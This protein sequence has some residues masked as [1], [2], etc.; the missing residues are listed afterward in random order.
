MSADRT[1]IAC[2][3]SKTLRLRVGHHSFEWSFLLAAVAFP[4]IG[5]DFL[6]TFD[7][8]INLKK[9]QLEHGVQQW[10]LHIATPPPSSMFAAIAVHPAVDGLDQAWIPAQR[11]TAR[12]T[13]R[14]ISHRSLNGEFPTICGAPVLTTPRQQHAKVQSAREAPAKPPIL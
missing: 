6:A 14:Q 9:M 3:G 5:A 13:P 12:S 1:A 11:A 2:W 8:K 4:I 10:T 7:L